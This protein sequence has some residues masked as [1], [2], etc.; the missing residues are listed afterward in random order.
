MW[1]DTHCHLDAVEFDV[2][3]D[4]V[5]ARARA[6]GVGM[7]V[8]PAV[9][10]DHIDAVAGLAHRHGVAYA[11]GMHPLWLDGVQ[12]GHVDRLD[13][14]LARYRDDP[15]LVAVGEIGIDQFVPDPD[16]ER[17]QFY[18]HAQ[19]R[20]ARRYD[21][22]VIL[23]VRRS[24]DLLL[25]HLRQVPVCGGI[26]HAFNGSEQQALHLVERG[27]ALGFGGAMT[28][29]GSRRIRRLAAGVPAQ[30]WV[31]E[32]DSPDM[33]PQWLRENGQAGRNE[34]AHLVRIARTMA[35][36]RGLP[37][38]EVCAA[39]LRNAQAAL[40]RLKFLMAASVA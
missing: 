12:P 2:D 30:G 1:I 15:H 40:P 36:Q 21:L 17:Q 3:R 14:A 29:D 32:T 5:V 8:I 4:A 27:F 22:P 35:E 31:L 7:L 23:H 25:K 28:Y 37:L 6:A 19:L 9:H 13:D 26:A 34:P 33:P 39:N 11:L 24:A 20:L 10:V 18:Y 16:L 38:A